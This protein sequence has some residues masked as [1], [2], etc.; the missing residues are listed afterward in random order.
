MRSLIVVLFLA[1]GLGFLSPARAQDA[2]GLSPVRVDS[3]QA[4]FTQE[5]TS[6]HPCS[7]YYL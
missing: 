3:V 2:A 7:S 4:E 1:A 6:A 5:K